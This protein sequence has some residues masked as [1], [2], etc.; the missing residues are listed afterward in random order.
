[1]SCCHWH[2]VTMSGP[3]LCH[4]VATQHRCFHRR[5]D[6]DR[7][8]MGW[9]RV[10]RDGEITSPQINGVQSGENCYEAEGWSGDVVKIVWQRSFLESFFLHRRIQLYQFCSR[11]NA[12][13]KLCGGLHVSHTKH[14]SYLNNPQCDVVIILWAQTPDCLLRETTARRRISSQTQQSVSEETESN[15]DL[16]KP[17]R[18]SCL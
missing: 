12:Q 5:R 14:K 10:M 3:T 2:S 4:N 18:G 8:H 6:G 7:G 11:P 1:M 9:H 17:V 15:H 13:V 16:Q